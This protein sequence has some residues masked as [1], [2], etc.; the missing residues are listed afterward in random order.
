MNCQKTLKLLLALALV[1]G[2]GHPIATYAQQDC[3]DDCPDGG[4]SDLPPVTGAGGSSG[5][6]GSS[7]GS[8]GQ[9]GPSPGT[10]VV[11]VLNQNVAI[12]MSGLSTI[13][14]PS[15]VIVYAANDPATGAPQ[16]VFDNIQYNRSGVVPSAKGSAFTQSAAPLADTEPVGAD[17]EFTVDETDFSLPGN[18]IPFV[19]ARHYRSGIDYQ[20]Y[21]GYGWS[22]SYSQ[23]LVATP[24]GTLFY[25]ALG[26][27]QPPSDLYLTTDRLELHDFKRQGVSSD[28]TRD[29]YT[30]SASAATLSHLRSDA[31]AEWDLDD[32]S[33]LTVVF[34]GDTGLEQAVVDK[35]NHSIR[36]AWLNGFLGPYITT[37]T[38][39]TGRT[40]YFNYAPLNLPVVPNRNDIGVAAQ[41]PGYQNLQCLS[42]APN[43]DNP[44]VSFHVNAIIAESV[45]LPNPN[46][47]GAPVHN[48]NAEFDLIGVQDADGN[49]PAY[50]YYNSSA[51][52]YTKE[53]DDYLPTKDAAEVYDAFSKTTPIS[54][55][56]CSHEAYLA[57]MSG[58]CSLIGSDYYDC[59]NFLTQKYP[60]ASYSNLVKQCLAQTAKIAKA[61]AKKQPKSYVYGTPP[62]LYHDLVSIHD[63]D[64]RLVV[65]NRYGSD[66]FQ[67]DFDRIT[68]QVLAAD[69]TNTTN[70]SY[71][72][73]TLANASAR[74]AIA[75]FGPIDICPVASDGSYAQQNQAPNSAIAQSQLPALQVTVSGPLNRVTQE[76]IDSLGRLLRSVDSNGVATNYNYVLPGVS[77]V[78]YPTG[79][80]RCVAYT[81][82]GRASSS[83][84]LPAFGHPGAPLFTDWTYDAANELVGQTK[85]SGG[86]L[87]QNT[88]IV[89]DSWERIIAVGEAVDSQHT[90]WTCFEYDDTTALRSFA[91]SVGL[92]ATPHPNGSIPVIQSLG[93]GR[94]ENARPPCL[95]Q[96]SFGPLNVVVTSL[97]ALPSQITRPDGSITKLDNITAA[98]PGD[99]TVDAKGPAPQQL[100]FSYDMFGS[101]LETGQRHAGASDKIAGSVTTWMRDAAGLVQ[102]MSEPDP[103]SSEAS[104]VT[105]FRYD[106]SRNLIA[107][108][109][110][111]LSRTFVT[112][113]F[114]HV[115]SVTETPAGTSGATGQTRITCAKYDPYGAITEQ[116]SAEGVVTDFSY[117]TIGQL[118][119]VDVGAKLQTPQLVR[120]DAPCRPRYVPAY[121]IARTPAQETFARL[122][123]NAVEQL[124]SATRYGLGAQYTYD[125]LDRLIDTF[126]LDHPGSPQPPRD[127]RPAITPMI[128]YHFAVGYQG[129]SKAWE[130]IADEYPPDGVLPDNTGGIH[131]AIEYSYDLVGRPLQIGRWLFPEEGATIYAP[132]RALTSF[133][134]DDAANQTQI[135]D[136]DDVIYSLKRDGADR[137]VLAIVG[138]D[139]PAALSISDAYAEAGAVVN[140]TLTPLPRALDRSREHI[141]TL[142]PGCLSV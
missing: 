138:L 97:A 122:N 104:V 54:Q 51:Q 74:S 136:S 11:D 94:L 128:G 131:A 48:W 42:L 69:P 40:I 24:T 133:V 23:R 110:P 68:R 67:V 10:M 56:E 50:S 134:Y 108:S 36:I 90:R 80:R 88:S 35:A 89:R 112:D 65:Q 73:L 109:S 126:V 113:T 58:Y 129:F 124:S 47:K 31:T 4:D 123:Y 59:S 1:C 5:G 37:I 46:K 43:C 16:G 45:D 72:D 107:T 2:A 127:G 22:N 6:G 78:L 98:G 100:Y 26:T 135:T 76:S 121:T 63:A 142:R 3:A 61:R 57:V 66:P 85:T 79:R 95:P 82:A 118:T 141:P 14:A 103:S 106:K 13:P 27:P 75:A 120:A 15:A 49:G 20:S 25:P 18:G 93:G 139:T 117:N 60:K 39:T 55:L 116:I 62:S 105:T 84:E 140:E 102:S 86:D 83:T 64:G 28:G 29:I 19:F 34:A 71:V 130:A 21:L 137:P 81:P 115:Q 30:D 52:W 41:V 114:G 38:D 33:G 111:K 125:G 92:P 99:I 32:G 91:R 9:T 101:L 53:F 8:G 87:S 96:A 70:F 12:H 17:G 7:S 77:G 119:E 132:P 44:L